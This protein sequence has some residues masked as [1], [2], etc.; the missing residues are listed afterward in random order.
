MHVKKTHIN[1]Q[2]T[3]PGRHL[4]E[5]CSDIWICGEGDNRD[6]GDMGTSIC[7]LT[8][9]HTITFSLGIQGRKTE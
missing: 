4:Q 9:I 2:I 7:T 5:R 3:H 6:D 8:H 1:S